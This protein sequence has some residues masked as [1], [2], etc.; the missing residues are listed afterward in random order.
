VVEM[1]MARLTAVVGAGFFV[2]LL[3]DVGVFSGIVNRDVNLIGRGVS[4]LFGMIGGIGLPILDRF[5]SD[6]ATIHNILF[7]GGL[8]NIGYLNSVMALF[9]SFF[10]SAASFTGLLPLMLGQT[11]FLLK[12]ITG[13]GSAI[14]TPL[15]HAQV[16]MTNIN[17]SLNSAY[18]TIHKLLVPAIGV[19]LMGA[20]FGRSGLF[21]AIPTAINGLISGTMSLMQYVQMRIFKSIGIGKGALFT[22][23]FDVRKFL[24]AVL[25]DLMKFVPAIHLIAKLLDKINP[26][27]KSLLKSKQFEA[28]F[29]KIKAFVSELTKIPI[30]LRQIAG[31]TAR[32][33]MDGAEIL[34]VTD[35]IPER[36]SR[37]RQ[38]LNALFSLTGRG[39]RASWEG[40]KTLGGS[41]KTSI[42]DALPKAGAAIGKMLAIPARGFSKISSLIVR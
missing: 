42:I 28:F 15:Q 40:I 8:F 9:G 29:E 41:V 31:Y 38:G 33:G 7:A 6:F 20:F 3:R 26:V 37:L 22:M 13:Q 27:I 21:T 30:L 16:L 1:T 5:K 23:F 24:L 36:V 39:V 17:T 2:K 14:N 10:R 25:P 18:F 11:F 19:G 12:R 35:V 4:S 32:L 34:H